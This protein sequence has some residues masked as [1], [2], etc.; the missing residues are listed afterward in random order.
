[1]SRVGE[2]AG[3]GATRRSGHTMRWLASA[4]IAAILVVIAAPHEAPAA[5][6]A[7]RHVRTSLTFEPNQGQA[8]EGVS[9]VARGSGYQ[10]SLSESEL[11]LV[12]GGTARPRAAAPA[13]AARDAAAVIR[14]A[15]IGARPVTP[16]A[17][18][19][20]D[21]R[22]NYFVGSDPAT[23][24]T[25]IPTYGRISAP[26]V[27]PGVDLV[28]HG[29]DQRLEY[30]FVVAAGADPGVIRLAV[31]DPRPGAMPP[32]VEV[33]AAGALLVHASGT[34]VRLPQPVA[35]QDVAGGSRRTIPARYAIAR[36]PESG[37]TRIGFEVAPYDITRTLVIDPVVEYSMYL[38]GTQVDGA[39][40]LAV[41]SDGSVYV[42]GRTT[43]SDFPLGSP[44]LASGADA[45]VAK[46]DATGT[47]GWVT[48]L[49]GNGDDEGLGIVV[50]GLGRISVVGTTGSSNFPR[51]NAFQ[52]LFGGGGTDAFV[53]T[54]SSTG[55]LL[56]STYL[57]GE[58]DD[59]G[60]GI[61]ADV[62]DNLYVTGD[63]ASS[64]FPVSGFSPALTG[65]TDAFVAKVDPAATGASSLLYSRRLGGGGKEEGRG[66]AVD[67]TGA[68]YVVGAT[69][70]TDFPVTASAWPGP[71][72]GPAPLAGGWDAFVASLDPT[73]QTITYATLLGGTGDDIAL[74]VSLWI[75]DGI[76]AVT[77]S[78]GSAEFPTKDTAFQPVK[79]AGTDA[80]VALVNT[81]NAGRRSLVYSTF[82]GG[83]GDDSGQAVTVTADGLVYVT[84]TT[85]SDGFP[86]Q[87]PASTRGGGSD[88][89]VARLDTQQ[90]GAASLLFST[91]IGGS[92][93]DEGHGIG[94]DLSGDV[95]VAGVTSSSD[96]PH[97]LGGSTLDGPQDAFVTKLTY[98]DLIVTA[99]EAP[100]TAIQGEVVV[101]RVTVKNVGGMT[102]APSTL[103]FFVRPTD[104]TLGPE[105]PVDYNHD[106]AAVPELAP[107]ASHA[108]GEVQLRIPFHAAGPGS[109]PHHFIAMADGDDVVLEGNEDNNR[110]RL[111]LLIRRDGPDLTLT[112]L[113]A[114]ASRSSAGGAFQMTDTT[115]NIGNEASL[116][117]VT[118]FWLSRTDTTDGN[119]AKI[120]S[121][122]VP[123]LAPHTASS[124]TTT[125]HVPTTVAVGNYF[126]LAI[127][128]A[129]RV[130]DEDFTNNVRARAITIGPDLV[131]ESVT[132]TDLGSGRF[133]IRD[134]TMNLYKVGAGA[135]KTAF[136]LSRTSTLDGMIARLGERSVGSFSTTTTR[137]KGKVTLPV[138]NTLTP[139][140][141]W[142]VAKADDHNAVPELVE[143]N[144]TLATPIPIGAD[145]IVSQLSVPGTSTPGTTIT[146]RNRIT[147]RG[148]APAGPSTVA[149]SIARGP[150]C[151]QDVRSLATRSIT[152]TLTPGQANSQDTKV[153]LP[154]D[155]V[156]GVSCVV[157][158]ADAGNTV[159]ETNE[160]NNTATAKVTISVP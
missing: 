113:G 127:A 77:G 15:L 66:V 154:G 27:Y 4:M 118:E 89:F 74:G 86:V 33:D 143:D 95:Y 140:S 138:P 129:G 96:L 43:S 69:G 53:T 91:Y 150:A 70:S 115:E 16:I 55:A 6:A 136:Y 3:F 120:G 82:L 100:D 44:G 139:G 57:G 10:L 46:L 71:A 42:T 142:L 38:G 146:V 47:V 106:V 134:T 37:V 114:S 152:S 148:S 123:A 121:R 99:F 48:Y 40:A 110:M 50:D 93:A 80:F 39:A 159:T 21:T 85:A 59:R 12:L 45:F 81:L 18:M 84:G 144:N 124:A 64:T 60:F 56:Y 145:L 105:T 153:T 14:M 147:N 75:T 128:N 151:N 158:R 108:T 62:L 157:V 131:I 149:I 7:I 107:G 92:G 155:L 83:E 13:L 23:W 1:M 79:G 132:F 35:Y 137:N 156:A 133:D 5:P 111:A 97:L 11:L 17:S 65:A 103:R 24:R 19:P 109:G 90:S 141:Y 9:F 28:Y 54:L 36:D 116:A 72:G 61:T 63:T 135:S 126:I 25:S 67:S 49:G 34:T 122:S 102:A 112:A 22:V 31:D 29:S 26:G 117:S 58:Q 51:V 68:V 104:R 32:A 52:N 41:G 78:T 130:R 2:R 73:A 94:V 76:V 119:V 30:D 88:A 8:P 98:P 20:L 87:D 160:T 125:V 101:V